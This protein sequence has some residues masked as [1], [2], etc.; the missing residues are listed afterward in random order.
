MRFRRAHRA[1]FRV[2]RVVRP[3]RSVVDTRRDPG[4]D[5]HCCPASHSRYIHMRIEREMK[6]IGG[7]IRLAIPP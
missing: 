7:V 3:E 1:R 6:R 2:L 5:R 4:V